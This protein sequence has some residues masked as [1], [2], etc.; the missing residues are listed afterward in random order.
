MD[1]DDTTS[2]PPGAVFADDFEVQRLVATEVH[3]AVYAA[4][5]R[6]TGR[7]RALRVL[8]ALGDDAAA[9]RAGV[10]HGGLSPAKVRL[11][12]ARTVGLPFVAKVSDV[13]V[14]RLLHRTLGDADTV[15][16]LASPQWMAPEQ[17]DP[18]AALTPATDVFAFGLLTFC[19]PAGLGHT[20]HPA[21]AEDAGHRH[22]PAPDSPADA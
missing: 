2:L 15:R 7:P 22:H 16:Y 9:H 19:L 12:E 1:S 5:P 21:P 13:G 17:T 18:A 4:L 8:T 3:G 11:T 20:H 10:V 14:D 6:S